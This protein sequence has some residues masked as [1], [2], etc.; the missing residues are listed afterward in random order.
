MILVPKKYMEADTLL[1]AWQKNMQH[2]SEQLRKDIFGYTTRIHQASM[3]DPKIMKQLDTQA[4]SKPDVKKKN[5]SI[6]DSA[7]VIFPDW[8]NDD[9]HKDLPKFFGHYIEKYKTIDF[10]PTWGTYFERFSNFGDEH[11]NP[12]LHCINSMNG[13]GRQCRSVFV[14]HV[15]SPDQDKIQPLGNPCL[16]YAEIVKNHNDT[17][18]LYFSYRAQDFFGKSIG[19]WIGLSRMLGFI[20]YHTQF[21]MGELVGFSGR[22]YLSGTKKDQSLILKLSKELLL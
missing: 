20:C 3:M 19:N 10:R 16:Q 13:W 9:V 14:F 17:L 4:L 22:A 11:K 6:F 2:L 5:P 1:E 15:T 8:V 21:K 12:I 7:N 18:S